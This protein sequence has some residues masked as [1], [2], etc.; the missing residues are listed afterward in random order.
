MQRGGIERGGYRK[1]ISVF[2]GKRRWPVRANLMQP[3]AG[4]ALR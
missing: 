1:L 2:G 3:K 4:S